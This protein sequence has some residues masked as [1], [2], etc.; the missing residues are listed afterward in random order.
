MVL[1]F[2]GRKDCFQLWRSEVALGLR[3]VLA[4]KNG[5]RKRFLEEEEE[6][7]WQVDTIKEKELTI[8]NI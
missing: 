2:S 4:L 1:K 5:G 8:Y 6:K 3:I 7:G